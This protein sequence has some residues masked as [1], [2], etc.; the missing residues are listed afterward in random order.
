MKI[1]KHHKIVFLLLALLFIL[2]SCKKKIKDPIPD[3]YVSF[4]MNISSTIYL[5]LS[6]VGGWV[7]LTGGYKGIIVYRKS[8]DEF[9]AFERACPNDWKI[10]SAYVSV[11]PSGLILKCRSCG[12]DF[13]IL[14]GSVV[15]G[16]S[17]I[18]LKQYYT[19]YDGQMLHVFN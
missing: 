19:D 4:Y 10:D 5:E 16:P 3:V 15:N 14:D 8:T 9:M 18:P 11:E 1:V 17:E 6:S 2:I 13:L 12:S 7:N